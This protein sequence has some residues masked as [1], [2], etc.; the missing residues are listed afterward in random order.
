MAA[1]APE[2]AINAD[3]G[4]RDANAYLLADDADAFIR[5]NV[6]EG[7]AA[8]EQATPTEKVRALVGASRLID[9]QNWKGSKC[10]SDQLLDFPRTQTEGRLRFEAGADLTQQA[11]FDA[12]VEADEYLRQ[13]KLRVRAATCVQACYTLT[14]PF[15][16]A[17]DEQYRG[18]TST[19]RSH[20]ISQ[21]SGYGGTHMDLCPDAWDIL[22]EF[23]STARLVRG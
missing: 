15:D 10:R 8:W 1:A 4:G 7:A 13:Q 11:V 9:G 20:R 18:M 16:A 23:R 19:S 5:F 22:G 3:W 2:T 14:R 6:Q 21:S 12:V 17:R